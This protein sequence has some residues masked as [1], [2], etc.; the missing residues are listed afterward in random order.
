MPQI[1]HGVRA[2]LSNSLIYNLLQAIMGAHPVRQELING[3]IRPRA[4]M[5]VLDIACGTAEILEYLPH[6]IEYVGY[7]ISAKYISA[8]R[9]RFGNRGEFY[10][11]LF[12]KDAAAKLQPFDLVLILGGIHHM[13]DDLVRSLFSLTA[14]AMA[15]TGRLITID[16]CYADRQNPIARFLISHDRGQNV[17]TPQSYEALARSVFPQT[18]GTLRHRAWVPYT[19]WIMECSK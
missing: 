1:T 13:D 6:E 10:C 12:D 7:D 17:R 15:P 18:N 3:H 2:I 14:D 9:D 19:H 4:G 16:P 5:R 11:G 8:A